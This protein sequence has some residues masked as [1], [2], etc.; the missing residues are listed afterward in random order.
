MGF[1]VNIAYF[2]VKLQQTKKFKRAKAETI[3]QRDVQQCVG[4]LH[5][6]KIISLIKFSTEF[7]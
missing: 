3:N 5:Y 2:S 7:A 4:C 6:K 1:F